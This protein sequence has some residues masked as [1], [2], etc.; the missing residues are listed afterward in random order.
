MQILNMSGSALRRPVVKV[1]VQVPKNC[2]RRCRICVYVKIK[3]DKGS[4]VRNH[5]LQ[6]A[7]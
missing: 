4:H 7:G 6:G 2:R 5:G 1:Y 3:W